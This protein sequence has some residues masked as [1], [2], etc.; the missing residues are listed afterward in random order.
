[1]SRNRGFKGPQFIAAMIVWAVRSY[2]MFP[3]SY[4][5]LGLMLL[6]RGVAV[7]HSIIFRWIQAYAA[8]LEK[9]NRPHLR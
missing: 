7:E 8:E 2:L 6:D 1:M 3:I 5:D 9:R 4:R